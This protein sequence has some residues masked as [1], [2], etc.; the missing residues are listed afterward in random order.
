MT[1]LAWTMM[2]AFYQT[3]HF[4][5]YKEIIQQLLLRAM[6]IIATVA[7]T[8]WSNYV[9]NKWP[10]KKSLAITVN[11]ETLPSRN[12]KEKPVIRFKNPVVGVVTI[13]DLI[14]VTLW[15]QQRVG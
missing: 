8:N 15:L 12:K 10:I 14:K 7:K 4:D 3:H 5:R 13:P 2:Q 11:A 9:P 6:L 1:W